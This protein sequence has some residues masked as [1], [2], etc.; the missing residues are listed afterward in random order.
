MGHIG[1]FTTYGFRARELHKHEWFIAC[2][3]VL[4]TPTRL[5]A[6]TGLKLVRTSF[7]GGRLMQQILFAQTKEAS[8]W[9]RI[10]WAHQPL[11]HAYSRISP[12]HSAPVLPVIG[13]INGWEGRGSKAHQF[14]QLALDSDPAYR[15]ASST[16]K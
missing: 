7:Q 3:S 12:E 1:A 6:Q 14:L 5:A 16:T 13:Y 8:K 2:H 15:L 10:K 11:L 4:G 9:S